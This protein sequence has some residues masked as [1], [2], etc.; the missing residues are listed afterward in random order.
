DLRLG[1]I[2]ES[3]TPES[4]ELIAALT[5]S[6]SFTMAGYYS[7]PQDL[8]DAISQ[9]RIH[10]GVVIPYDYARSLQ[11]GQPVTVQFLLHSMNA[12]TARTSR[13]LGEGVIKS[14]NA[15]VRS[16]GLHA[17]FRQITATD[18]SRRGV[19]LLTPAFLYNPGLVDTWFIVT[20][21]FGLLLI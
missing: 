6:K 11:H 4:R 2:D 1:V 19:V 3:R 9:G 18:V 20:G 14:Y 8:G 7:S 21:V 10:T 15:G 12:N 16:G 5:E 13:G 17:A